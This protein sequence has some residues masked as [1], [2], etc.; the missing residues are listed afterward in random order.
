MERHFEHK[1]KKK[2]CGKILRTNIYMAIIIP[3]M[4]LESGL[5]EFIA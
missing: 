5:L 3:N 2:I 4:N 1:N